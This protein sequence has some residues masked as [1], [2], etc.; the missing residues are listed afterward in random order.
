MQQLAEHSHHTNAEVVMAAKKL[1]PPITATGMHLMGYPIADWLVCATLAYTIVQL[2][3]LLEKRFNQRIEESSNMENKVES[4]TPFPEAV[5][6]RTS[7]CMDGTW[8]KLTC[9]EFKL[10]LHTMERLWADNAQRVSC[11]P[12]GRYLVEATLSKRFKR[13]M[14]CLVGVPDR[15]GIRIHP[16]NWPDELEGCIALGT[17]TSRSADRKMLLNSRV[18]VTHLEQAFRMKPFYLTVRDITADN[19]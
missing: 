13:K 3:L 9:T 5:L 16:A 12:A 19:T 15:A 17:S 14:Y 4:C 6:Q 8:G 11:I 7:S 18:G 2:V 10:E 1:A